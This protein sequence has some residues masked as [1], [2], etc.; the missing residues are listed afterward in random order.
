MSSTNLHKLAKEQFVTDLTGSSTLEIINIML[1]FIPVYY[2]TKRIEENIAF[3]FVL[4]FII[5]LLMVTVYNDFKLLLYIF[6]VV[7]LLFIPKKLNH[8]KQS[9]KNHSNKHIVVAEKTKKDYLTAYRSHMLIM[10]ALAILAVD[11]KVFPRKLGKVETWGTSLMDLG[12]GSFI[13]SNG[14]VSKTNK[15]VRQKA[16][17]SS[18]NQ[19]SNK[20]CLFTNLIIRK[21]NIL[22]VLG[23]LRLFFV[24][25]LEY[26]EHL[27]EYG[28]HWNFFI[29]LGLM[30]LTYDYIINPVLEFTHINRGV[31]GL[32]LCSLL[33]VW[34]NLD[35]RVLSYLINAERVGVV[36]NNR[37]GIY[38]LTGYIGIFLLGQEFGNKIILPKGKKTNEKNFLNYYKLSDSQALGAYSL[39]LWS[40][41]QMVLSLD[42]FYI[43]RRFANLPYVLWVVS[44]N[45]GF[46]TLYCLVDS[47]TSVSSTDYILECLNNNGLLLFLIANVS[48]GLVNMSINTISC[49]PIIS[50]AV[51][52][53]Y[54]SLLFVSAMVMNKYKIR[55]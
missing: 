33:E 3:N 11:F 29:T 32:L 4:H 7:P 55:I 37:E 31:F 47:L 53:G 52:I 16:T 20:S 34:L 50:T 5:P 12:V 9:Y 25:N 2:T 26:Q 40:I 24:K 49:G 18:D 8:N 45:L 10:T 46:L 38:S 30:P 6:A 44:Y 28:K 51:L 39:L 21:S 41:N 43:S 22:F 54:C 35:S 13:F 17:K 14:I 23:L 1:I 48:T 15:Q 27:S 42:N 19:E 36:G